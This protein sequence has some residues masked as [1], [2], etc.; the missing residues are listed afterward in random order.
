MMIGMTVAKIAVSVPVSVVKRVRRA[1]ARG[2]AP[3]V[4]AYVTAALEHKAQLDEL[5]EMLAEMLE[6]TGGPPTATENREADR[7]LGVAKRRKRGAA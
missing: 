7:I 2:R 5:E 6:L 3:S 4:S 1:V